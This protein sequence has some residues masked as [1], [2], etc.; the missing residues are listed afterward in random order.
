MQVIQFPCKE[1][2]HAATDREKAR[3]RIGWHQIGKMKRPKQ[4][5]A[6]RGQDRF[7]CTTVWGCYVRAGLT[8]MNLHVAAI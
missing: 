8:M 5:Q 1:G 7:I 2:C 4:A 3:G 6:Q